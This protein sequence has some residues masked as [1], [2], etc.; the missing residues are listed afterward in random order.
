M[1]DLWTAVKDLPVAI[2]SIALEALVPSGPVAME[3][4]STTQV[5]LRCR[6]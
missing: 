2:E 6:G 5:R 3:D 4:F 1:T